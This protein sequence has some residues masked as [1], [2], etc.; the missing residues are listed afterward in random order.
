MSRDGFGATCRVPEMVQ[1][2]YLVFETSR[3]VGSAAR[4]QGVVRLAI[5]AFSG[6]IQCF[7][8]LEEPGVKF[9]GSPGYE[10]DFDTNIAIVSKN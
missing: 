8:D 6:K 2:G 5:F 9:S 1:N 10:E 7:S 3:G 4:F